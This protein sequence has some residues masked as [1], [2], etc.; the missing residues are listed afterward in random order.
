[1]GMCVDMS[2]G[3]SVDMSMGMCVDMSMG[4]SVDMSMG[5]CVD[6]S[7]GMCVDMSMGMCPN[8]WGAHALGPRS[9]DELRGWS[10]VY[11]PP[12]SSRAVGCLAR[13]LTGLD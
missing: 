10:F 3:M 11:L 8:G 7:M 2:I 4:M 5:M 9:R 1:M 6:V 12:R 13:V